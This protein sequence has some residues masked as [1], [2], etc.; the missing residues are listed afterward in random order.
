MSR[1]LLHPAPPTTSPSPTPT[2]SPSPAHSCTQPL[3]HIHLVFPSYQST[4]LGGFFLLRQPL[5]VFTHF[6]CVERWWSGGATPGGGGGGV[7]GPRRR[8]WSV[9]QPLAPGA[10]CWFQ[11]CVFCCATRH[12]AANR[13]SWSP[14][15]TSRLMQALKV[16]LE[17]RVQQSPTGP[18]ISRDQLCNN[19][20]W[21]QISCQVGTRSWSQCRLKW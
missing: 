10:S 20:P 14:E 7:G 3:P 17:S 1:P 4:N 19:L 13:G 18:Q 9:N 16:H 15:E 8:R 21:N 12:P 2:P 5:H 6:L 11:T